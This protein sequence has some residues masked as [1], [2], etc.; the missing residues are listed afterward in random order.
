MATISGAR[1][2]GAAQ[3]G[4]RKEAGTLFLQAADQIAGVLARYA[5][6]DDQIPRDRID[7]VQRAAG[8]IVQALFVSEDGRSAFGR[9][10]VTALAPFPQL[11]NKWYVAV[12][13]RVVQAHHDW[14]RRNVPEDVFAWLAGQP[15]PR[16][17]GEIEN[18]FLRRDDESDDAYRVRLQQL[19]LFE[20][21][22]L[23][24]YDSMHEWVDPNGYRLSD[25]VWRASVHT[26][27][28]IDAMVA[29]RIREGASARR[30]ARELE[31][32]LHPDRAA[33]RTRR[34]YGSDAS[35]DAMRLARTEITAAHSR[36][37]LESARHNPYVTAVDWVLSPSHPRTD[38][39]DDWAAG[40]PYPLDNAPS[41]PDHPHCLCHLAPRVTASPAEVT[42][43]IR[44]LI[45]DEQFADLR[46]NPNPAN[47]AGFVQQLV[48]EQ[49]FR[50]FLF[51]L[52]L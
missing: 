3:R 39:C 33:L 49:L 45:D 15:V 19:R 26:R 43:Q 16:S 6:A 46:P 48:G 2:L 13:Y 28:Q 51:Q 18:P 5:D 50:Q 34:P 29:T 44:A 47:P 12:T 9:D 8:E 14:L 1:I 52:P 24:Q 4:F 35:F 23:A 40:G 37:M 41:P 38:R 25:R 32:F 30:L 17:F 20:P 36:A 42:A 7:D 11:L 21:N 27:Q 22:P 10:A 31:R